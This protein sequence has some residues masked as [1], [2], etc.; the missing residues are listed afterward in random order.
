MKSYRAGGVFMY[1]QGNRAVVQQGFPHVKGWCGCMFLFRKVPFLS[2]IPLHT[3]NS[4][5]ERQERSGI[6]F[7]WEDMTWL[8]YENPTNPPSDVM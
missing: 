2:V 3:M 4:K 7:S 6:S 5:R 1:N 8:S